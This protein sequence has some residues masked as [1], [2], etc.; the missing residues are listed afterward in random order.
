MCSGDNRASTRLAFIWLAFALVFGMRIVVCI[1]SDLLTSKTFNTLRTRYV[2][3]WHCLAL[4]IPLVEY[5]AHGVGEWHA[6]DVT[7]V[8]LR[9][10]NRLD[11]MCE[12]THV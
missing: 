5:L 11:Y 7:C 10:R 1:D 8:K 9:I 6:I 2:Q 12:R 3:A 4:G